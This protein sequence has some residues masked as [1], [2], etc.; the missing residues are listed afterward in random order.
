MN[1]MREALPLRYPGHA[2]SLNAR[3]ADVSN[4]RYGCYP[5]AAAQV[6]IHHDLYSN[7][8]RDFCDAKTRAGEN[9]ME[10]NVLLGL[11]CP[12]TMAE[13]CAYAIYGVLVSQVYMSQA[14]RTPSAGATYV[15]QLDLIDL[16]RRIPIFYSELT[17]DNGP[18][19]NADLLAA[20]RLLEP[21][22]PHLKAMISALFRGCAHGWCQ[23]TQD[24]LRG[25]PIDNLSKSSR[26]LIVT[27]ATNC[28]NEG[29]LGAWRVACKARPN[30]STANFSVREQVKRNGTDA[31]I[32]AFAHEDNHQYVMR[33]VREKD[34]SGENARLRKEI[35]ELIM[36][37]AEETRARKAALVED[38]RL[39]LARLA[40]VG[41]VLDKIKIKKMVVKDLR[42]QL[43]IYKNIVTD[44]IL[45]KQR[46]WGDPRAVLEEIVL[47]ALQQY[48][49]RIPEREPT[50]AAEKEMEA[51]GDEQEE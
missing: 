31:W 17:L 23:F 35:A 19:R 39:E 18:I 50:E 51:V 1:Y 49:S 22:L 36:R 10:K 30:I 43:R 7:L 38:R 11:E 24:F 3:I 44:P 20:I 15:N 46:I 4:T 8:V 32:E 45:E 26:S 9:H 16:H 13:M 42:D 21:E 28:K 37:K 48:K 25:G 2:L 40:A 47:G 27:E 6:V 41:L 29:G 12:S 14:R 33:L 5:D 34:A